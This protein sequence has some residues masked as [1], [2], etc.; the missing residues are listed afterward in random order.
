[1][2][3]TVAW[4]NL[5]R[6]PRRTLLTASAIGFAVLLLMASQA[7][8]S[9][10]FSIMLKNATAFLTGQIQIQNRKYWNDHEFQAVIPRVNELLARIRKVPGVERASARGMAFALVSRGERS[11]GA[12]I[13][14]VDPITEPQ[15]S[16]LDDFVVDGGYLSQA[17]EGEAIIGRGLARNL[18]IA[19]GAQNLNQELAIL[20]STREGG[21]AATVVRVEGIFETGQSSLDRS[22]MQISLARFQSTFELEDAAHV[23]VGTTPDVAGSDQVARR[24][25]DILPSGVVA[26]SWQKLLPE[27]EQTIAM[28]RAGSRIFF[29][30]LALMVTFSIVN[31]FIM[32][33]FE[34]KPEFGMLLALGMRP[35]SIVGMLMLEALWM[36]L[37]GI[38]IGSLIGVVLILVLG[39]TGVPLG[40]AGAEVLERYHLPGR[41]Y[42]AFSIE[43]LFTGPLLMLLATQLAA[44][45]ATM[46]V[47]SLVPADAMKRV[48]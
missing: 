6:N 27:L 19:E 31:T 33:I 20:G 39:Q 1:M 12:Q 16:R 44:F 10:S 11:F 35:W 30:L 2:L 34:R 15:V 24:I 13:M 26:L 4:R 23:I 8:Q 17:A 42:P 3:L 5:W 40:D 37:L 38:L 7:L 22:L 9:G 32:T 14:G 29:V 41:M 45:L 28:K 47:R 21:L 25:Q 36:C 18:G 43:A 46:R 48:E